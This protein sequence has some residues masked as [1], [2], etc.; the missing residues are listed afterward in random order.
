M[1]IL[2]MQWGQHREFRAEQFLSMVVHEAQ[3]QLAIGIPV[4]QVREERRA[5]IGRTVKLFLFGCG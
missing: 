2:M 1:G 4:E 5:V 3:R